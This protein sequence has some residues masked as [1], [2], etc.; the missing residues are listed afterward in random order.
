M[1]TGKITRS[2]L[3]PHTPCGKHGYTARKVAAAAAKRSSNWTGERIEAYRCTRG[4][5]CWHIGH[6][7]GRSASRLRRQP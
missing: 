3:I 5:H 1:S 6:P 2:T 4:C 7:P